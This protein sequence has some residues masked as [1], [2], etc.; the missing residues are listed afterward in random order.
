MGQ[1]EMPASLSEGDCRD[2]AW[3]SFAFLVIDE[4]RVIHRTSQR[5]D[6]LFGYV[7]NELVGK[8]VEILVPDGIRPVHPGYVSG[9]LKNPT[10]RSMNAA[11]IVNGRKKDGTLINVVVSLASFFEQRH[12]WA[13][14]M[15]SEASK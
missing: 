15:V 3:R 2:Y 9:Y 1:F 7:R 8:P 14:A 4:A 6:D 5:L 11:R 12:Q 13:I 10:D